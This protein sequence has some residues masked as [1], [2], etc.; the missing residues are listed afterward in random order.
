MRPGYKC[1][2]AARLYGNIPIGCPQS[3]QIH[4]LTARG[5]YDL[6]RLGANRCSGSQGHRGPAG[7]AWLRD[8]GR[9]RLRFSAMPCDGWPGQPRI[10]TRTGRATGT[11]P[12][13]PSPN[14]RR[15]APSSLNAIPTR[16]CRNWMGACGPTCARPATSA[17]FTRCL[18]P[19]RTYPTTSMRHRLRIEI[20]ET[21]K[22][23][24]QGFMRC[25]LALQ[26]AE[27]WTASRKP[28]R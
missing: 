4:G 23:S 20:A 6:P 5:A 26:L 12:S 17:A 15:T 18:K 9:S 19:A 27:T 7:E 22:F 21:L 8:A 16:W 10:F 14:W 28:D 1:I 3:R 13:P 11:R 25:E 2:E 24:S